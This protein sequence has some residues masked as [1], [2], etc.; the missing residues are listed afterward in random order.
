MN[1]L[2]ITLILLACALVL[3]LT[4]RRFGMPYPIALTL[5]GLA[6]SFVPGLPRVGLDPHTVFTVFLPPIL[7]QAALTTSWRDF[8]ANL[9][10][11][12]LLAVGLVVTTTLAVGF[13]AHWLIPGLPLPVAFVLGAIVSPPDAVAAT[14]V[15]RKLGLP[16]R[17]VTV[18]EGE[19][20]VNDASG[21]VL[22][23]FAVAAVLTGEFSAS[24]AGLQFIVVAVGGV[25]FGVVLGRL[26][27]ALHSRFAD[28][29][30]EITLSIILPFAAYLAAEVAHVSGVLAVVVA[31]LVRGWYAP[32]I[33]T[34]QARQLA[35]GV[36]ELGVFVLTSLIFILI[37]LQLP[38]IVA[39]LAAYSWG[40]L[41]FYGVVVSLTAI[42]VRFAWVF[43]ATILPRLIS[44]RLRRVEPTPP[45]QTLVVI[46]WSGMRGVVSL[47]AALALPL[48]LGGEAPFPSRDLVIFLAF[49]VI[50]A[51]LVGQGL[52]LGP[53]IRRLSIPRDEGLEE[54]ERGARLETAHAAVAAMDRLVVQE[55]VPDALADPLREE[56]SWRIVALTDPETLQ[57]RR[58]TPEARNRR[59]LRLAAI[60]AERERVL[61]LRRNLVIGDEVLRRLQ[62]ELDLEEMRLS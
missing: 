33:F 32:E 57:L 51:T 58:E 5:G 35:V 37:G 60:A 4:A 54:E 21:L 25:L 50:L 11:I 6:L 10:P 15:M 40:A 28:P 18:L 59:R 22:Y 16:Q 9:R 43:P 49:A 36:W 30:L 38:Q 48:T 8:R 31:G 12:F 41:L 27:V 20:L 34:P 23:N 47:A 53:L 13:V 29:L 45:W 61:A 39:G 44:R 62:R 55:G 7:Y 1:P 14:A 3:G 24:E 42:V 46:S 52:T 2:E 56:Y 17:V 19:S 26:A